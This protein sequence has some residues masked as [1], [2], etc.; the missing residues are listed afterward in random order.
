MKVIMAGF[1]KTGTKTM[2]AAFK[3]L[4]LK[5]YDYL[6]SFW[7][8]GD[9][10]N[11]IL[12]NDGS[13]E[14]FKRMFEDVDSVTDMPACLY[15]EEI[16]QAFPDAKIVF[17][18]REENEWYT[19]LENQMR[20]FNENFMYKL[21][22]LLTP[23][24]R[25][26]YTFS[27]NLRIALLGQPFPHRFHQRQTNKMLSLMRYRRHNLYVMQKAPK[28]KLLVYDLK[29]G[30]EPLCKFLSV[31]VPNFPFPHKNKGASVYDEMME[32]NPIAKR[33]INELKVIMACI[34]FLAVVLIA[35]YFA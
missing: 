11:R 28:D 35:Y 12:T 22:Q 18:T 16:H 5:N 30:W 26:Y 24:G 25:K 14:D 8:H 31:E 6:E 1:S 32:E 27:N 13:V 20:S 21:L 2:S 23:S 3:L 4:G 33:V 19:S 34:G 10:W 7:F 17:T 9:D 29:Q 15:W